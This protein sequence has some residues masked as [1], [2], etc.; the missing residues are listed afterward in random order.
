MAASPDARL[1]AWRSI[2]GLHP[3]VKHSLLST[4]FMRP[5]PIQA[6][7]LPSALAGRDVVGVAQTGSGK[8]LAYGLPIID[9]ILRQPAPAPS[10]NPAK[11]KLQALILAPTRELALQVS[12]H[13]QKCA[14]GCVEVPFAETVEEAE[15]VADAGASDEDEGETAAEKG[16]KE[17]LEEN[18][19][20]KPGRNGRFKKKAKKEVPIPK[21]SAPKA[22]PTGP[23]PPPRVSVGSIVG[24]M[25]VDK[26]TRILKRGVDIL[27]ATP[28]RLW[29][30][31]GEVSPARPL[32]PALTRADI[33]SFVFPSPSSGRVHCSV[34]PRD[35]VPRHR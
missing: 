6:A 12:Q 11:R 9:Y 17:R 20:A 1:P 14:E 5:S 23:K 10:K 28:G 8:T 31:I 18:P 3:A 25:S 19:W 35:E 2:K 15:V 27:V 22:K 7:A 16:L 29:D 26:Q 32:I 24:G 34:D 30:L 4:S 21:A 33:H 13:L